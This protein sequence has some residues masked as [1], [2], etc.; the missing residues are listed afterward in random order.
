MQPRAM[1]QADQCT[2]KSAKDPS[3]DTGQVANR[4]GVMAPPLNAPS[5][6]MAFDETVACDLCL[7]NAQLVLPDEGVISAVSI[8]RIVIT[9]DTEGNHVRVGLVD[10]VKDLIIAGLTEVQTYSL[11]RHI[12]RRPDVD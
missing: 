6:T 5:S 8:E 7:A 3:G 9:Q 1:L 10:C 4:E 11:A 2:P 12:G